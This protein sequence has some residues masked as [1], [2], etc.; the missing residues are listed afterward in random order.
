MVAPAETRIDTGWNGETLALG[1]HVCYYYS[2]D[3][4]LRESL[5]FIRTGLDRPQEV[6]I[7]FADRSRFPGLLEWLGEGYDGDLEERVREGKLMTIPG[8]PA[9][10]D[11]VADI[12]AK[13]DAAV[14]AGYR[15]IRFLGFI[16]W[17]MA[18]WPGER[19][20]LEFESRVNDVVTQYP[21]V[22]VCTYGIPRLAGPSL[23][24]GGLQT[25]PLTVIDGG[26]VLPNPH[27][28]GTAE[29]IR[30]LPTA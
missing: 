22:I 11:I 23:I 24:Y 26:P 1:S 15:V 7:L 10:S 12:G 28:L 27:Y 21:A 4:A 3:A 14:A 6:G 9:V 16:G 20:L 17:E 2:G 19:E 5:V 18:G 30:R 13:L 8:A 29:F 25:H